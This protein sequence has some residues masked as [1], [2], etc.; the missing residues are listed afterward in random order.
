MPKRSSKRPRDVNVLARAIVDESTGQAKAEPD[1][2]NPHAVALGS[3]G[4]KKGGP[5][6][7][8]K[9]TPEQRREIAR[10]AA[11]ARWSKATQS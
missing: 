4:G 5:A 3:L 2:R 8:K 10:R 7:A 11:Q 9:L 6:R 1:T